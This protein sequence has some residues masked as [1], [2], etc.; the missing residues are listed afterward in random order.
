[1]AKNVPRFTPSVGYNISHDNEM[2]AMVSHVGGEQDT[3]KIGIDVMKR[4]LPNGETV[5][6]FLNAIEETVST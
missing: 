6:T 4:A 3:T 1:M 2:V 5:S